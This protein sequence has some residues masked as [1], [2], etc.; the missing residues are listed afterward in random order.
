MRFV[1]L[2][3]VL[4][5]SG[6]GVAAN[7][8]E[9]MLAYDAKDYQTAREGFKE[10]IEVGNDMAAYNLAAMAYRGE[11][12]NVDLAKAV[13][14]F[15]LAGELG[16]PSAGQLANQL[17]VKLTAEQNKSTRQQLMSLQQ[18][19]FI[20]RLVPQTT[21]FARYDMLTPIKR[22]PPR[23]PEDAALSGQFGYV[24]LRFLV[25]E[26]GAVTSVDTLD[27][28]PQGVFEK[29]AIRAVKRWQYQPGDKKHLV[30]VKLDY[31]LD[32]YVDAVQLT[33]L[34]EKE[35]LWQYAVA[36]APTYQEALGTLL[37]LASS[38]SQHY[39]V[40]DKTAKLTADLPDFAVFSSKKIPKVNI[41]QFS[42]WA[43]I[44]LNE[45]GVITNVSQRHLYAD[46]VD[47]DLVGLQVSKQ[48]IAGEYRIS[49][50]SDK[51]SVNIEVKHLI[52][53]ASTLTPNFW[54]EL[55]ARNGDKRAQHIMAANDSSWERYLLSKNDPV[56]MAWS[57]SKLI[58]DG[59]RKEGLALLDQAI[60]L[61]YPQAKELKKQFM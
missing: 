51:L 25:D 38:Y 10:L 43:S 50:L 60:A 9:A 52:R 26:S 32:G 22:V 6:A 5:W 15:E 61:H 56:V 18:Q 37:E 23:Y 2:T 1:F 35:K 17:R 36:G 13:A 39:F 14:L 4:L 49:R 3:C 8:L 31:T 57:G 16:H 48:S 28:F 34:I 24:N 42:G 44:T 29:S 46:S 11:G 40:D 12:E 45:Q 58:L 30:R 55:A 41:E 59:Y 21:D 7:W 20:P 47:M 33:K 53:V 27:A 19:V 54:W